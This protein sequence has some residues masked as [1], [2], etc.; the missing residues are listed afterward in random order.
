MLDLHLERLADVTQA[1][2]EPGQDLASYC[3]PPVGRIEVRNL[4]FRYRP[5]DGFVFEGVNFAVEP[6]DSLAISGPSGGG[7]TTL[8]RVLLG[9]L[10]PTDEEVL[11]DGLPLGTFSARTFRDHVG[12]V[13]QDDQL[14]SGSIADNIC[15]FDHELDHAHMQHCAKLACVHDDIRRHADVV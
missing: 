9:L 14:L 1:E 11:I 6:G 8:M 3:S 12:V 2:P 4:S 10:E 5:S 15:F 13:M 7:K